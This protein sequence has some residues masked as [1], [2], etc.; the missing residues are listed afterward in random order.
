MNTF[1]RASIRGGQLAAINSTD[2]EVG[3][4]DG[5][6]NESDE[7]TGIRTVYGDEATALLKRV[8]CHREPS[9]LV[10][11][12]KCCLSVIVFTALGWASF[13]PI[14]GW[15]FIDSLYF[16]MVTVTTV[17]YGDLTPAD[18]PGQQFFVACYAFFGVAFMATVLSELSFR[19]VRFA[20]TSAKV[21]RLKAVHESHQLVEQAMQAKHGELRHRHR[22]SCVTHTMHEKEAELVHCCENV[23]KGCR[24]AY[25]RARK[26]CGAWAVDLLL[27]VAEMVGMWSVGAAILM[28]TEGFSFS[29]SL[30]CAIITSLSVGYG[31][32]YPSV[33]L[34][35]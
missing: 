26:Q 30:Y 4:S 9:G 3:P 15:T 25:G 18:E 14:F 19:L 10:V 7:A 6:S 31:D 24:K 23:I 33:S 28:Q 13:S 12:F 29:Q 17:G 1:G 21:A 22:S 32:F 8:A 35:H 20:K 16:A 27:V 5:S 11:V 34:L 2:L